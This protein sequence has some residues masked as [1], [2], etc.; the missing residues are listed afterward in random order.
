MR[1]LPIL[2]VAAGSIACGETDE[3]KQLRELQAQWANAGSSVK[4]RIALKA[5][6]EA[7]LQRTEKTAKDAMAK[8]GLDL[9]ETKLK[10]E[11]DA[12]L[13]KIP[14]AT[15]ERTTR[16]IPDIGGEGGAVHETL[17][18]I[19]FDAKS[20]DQAFEYMRAMTQEPPLFLVATML[21]S[22]RGKWV[23]ELLRASVPEVPM[24]IQPTPLP[25]PKSA[26]TI[27]E[28]FGFC[29][30]G[31]IRKELMEKEAEF[32]KGK[33][34][35]EQLSVMLPKVATYEGLER[36]V[37][38]LGEEE[39][40]SRRLIDAFISAVKKAGVRYRAAGVENR[41]VIYEFHGGP[42]EK[43]KLEKALPEDVLKTM[44]ELE[45]SSKG[46][47]RLSVVNRVTD[48]QLKRSSSFKPGVGLAPEK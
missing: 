43:A 17:W 6:T 48:E 13:A 10:E 4:A 16:P 7:R 19:E 18:R 15:I 32:D 5:Q 40:E 27:P 11:L 21:H 3:C 2:L 34:D 28:E 1:A 45:S 12:R 8:I 35:A 26:S 9:P 39:R 41:V 47:V 29:G 46:V 42:K 37:T 25:K 20:D 38:L 30:A 33:A 23:L 36:R 22:D 24:N 14:G 31:A 44:K